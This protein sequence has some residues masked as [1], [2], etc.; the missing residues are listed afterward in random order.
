MILKS[1]IVEQ[2]IKSLESY[3]ATIIYGEN[4][5][6]KSDIKNQLKKDN[7]ESEIINLFQ[8]E[9]IGNKNILFDHISNESLFSSKKIIFLHEQT[10]KILDQ[11]VEILKI[12]NNNIKI[13]LFSNILEKKSKLRN[14]F[15][16]DKKLAAIACYIDTD[17]TLINY[18]N[19]KL[20]GFKGITPELVN[21]IMINS[22]LDRK[23]IGSEIEKIKLC[24]SEKN[25]DIQ[26][27]KDLLNIKYSLDFNKIRD[28]SFLGDKL[29]LNKLLSEINIQKEDSIFYVN[30]IN[31]RVLRL[32]EIK[33]IN[34]NMKNLEMTI[35]SFKN[36]I[37]WKDKPIYIKQVNKWTKEELRTIQKKIANT[38]LMIKTNSQIQ[39]D[40]IIKDL[41]I[42]I[43]TKA[44][45]IA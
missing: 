33:E 19:N 12:P 2:N 13:Y 3:R 4:D 11:I 32:L 14:L 16:K 27:V 21:Y 31:S 35:D 39:S 7:K 20:K 30:S 5:G 43:C 29:M 6:I 28:A 40:L 9:M 41:L 1:Y 18:I 24:F 38:E 10:D 45:A 8:D 25:I 42:N 15:E 23:V 17:R 34:E 22:S 44:S 36:K 26:E 37:F